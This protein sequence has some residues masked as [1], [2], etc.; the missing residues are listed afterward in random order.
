LAGQTEFMVLFLN[1]QADLRAFIGSLV[2]DR[3]TR[4]DLFQDVALTLWRKFGEYD[5]QRSFGAW[6]RGIAAKTILQ[7]WEKTGRFPLPLAPEA[8]QA[9][10]E[11]YDRTEKAASAR[12]DA[13]EQCLETLPDKSRQLLRLRYEQALTLD[14]IAR[15]VGSTLDAVHKALSRLRGR[16]QECVERRLAA[17]PES[18]P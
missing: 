6:A 9:I 4:E 2:R 5:P 8:M 16:L 14:Q 11:A 12:G 1:H 18:M 7:A 17:A 10:L 15:Q 13:L 3:H